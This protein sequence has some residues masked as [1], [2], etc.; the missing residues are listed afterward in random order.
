M[1]FAFQL[2]SICFTTKMHLYFGAVVTRETL[3]FH[4]SLQSALVKMSN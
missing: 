4:G 3:S 2:L 1:E